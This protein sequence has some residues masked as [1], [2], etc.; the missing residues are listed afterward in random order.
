MKWQIHDAAR[1][2]PI[3]INVLRNFIRGPGRFD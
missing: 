3:K 2:F 1:V